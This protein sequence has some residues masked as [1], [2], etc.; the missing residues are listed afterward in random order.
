LIPAGT[1]LA[2]HATRRAASAELSAAE[3]DGFRSSGITFSE[4]LSEETGSDD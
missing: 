3:L 1:G 2:Y 4:P